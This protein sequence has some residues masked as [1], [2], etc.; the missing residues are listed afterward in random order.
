M[1]M[2]GK[3]MK[4][5]IAT[6]ANCGKEVKKYRSQVANSKAYYCSRACYFE[7]K[8]K[9][10][11]LPDQRGSKNPFWKGGVSNVKKDCSRYGKEF[12]SSAANKR[13]YCSAECGYEDKKNRVVATCKVCGKEFEAMAY[14]VE[15]GKAFLCSKDCAGK[16]YT[17][18]YSGENNANFGEEFT[19]EHRQKIGDAHAGEKNYRWKGGRKTQ[20]G[21]QWLT[22]GNRHGRRYNQEHRTIAE[23]SLGRPLLKNEVVHH[24]NGDRSDNRNANLLI[25]DTGYH[26][27]L[28]HKM[29]Y[30]YQR[31]HFAEI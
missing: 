21:Y 22:T 15:R 10:M 30:L 12:F 1:A 2:K 29:S 25:C 14:A 18:N 3:N 4:S 5:I 17:E 24:I 11:S 6:C 19:D 20:D 26:M 28:H 7:A 31:E 23:K 9:G 13:E 27:W 16:W 8:K